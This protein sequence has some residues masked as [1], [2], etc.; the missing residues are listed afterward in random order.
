M[1]SAPEPTPRL[2]DDDNINE[3]R[4]LGLQFWDDGIEQ[5]AAIIARCVDNIERENVR[6]KA[7]VAELE[8]N[9]RDYERILGPKSYQEVAA[10][11]TA[12]RTK[13]EE[14]EISCENERAA[15]AISQL[16]CVEAEAKLAKAEA[17]HEK[18]ELNSAEAYIKIHDDKRA[19]EQELE[20]IAQYPKTR[21]DELGYEACRLI[22]KAALKGDHHG[23]GLDRWRVSPPGFIDADYCKHCNATED[24]SGEIKH[25]AGCSVAAE[26]DK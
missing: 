19:L 22:A 4:Q 7:K 3:L 21:G 15:N 1:T 6:I 2:S 9:E 13:R 11:L 18:F 5:A 12:E 20:R 23:S 14:A 26:D 16:K 24:I 8:E 25:N 17:E 10:D